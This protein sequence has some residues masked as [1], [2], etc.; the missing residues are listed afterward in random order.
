MPNQFKI[1]VDGINSLQATQGKL[2]EVIWT[3]RKA[4]V[5]DCLI[6]QSL[7]K[8]SPQLESLKLSDLDMT[9]SGLAQIHQALVPTHPRTNQ[10]HPS[11]SSSP[12]LVSLDLNRNKLGSSDLIG[13]I[14]RWTRLEKVLLVRNNLR[15]PGL[16]GICDALTWNPVHLKHLDL[17]SNSICPLGA[18]RMAQILGKDR[19]GLMKLGLGY[20]LL[21]DVGCQFICR[22]LTR[23]DLVNCNRGH[24]SQSRLQ[25][26]NLSHNQIT[27]AA[28]PVICSMI[29]NNVGLQTL[30][31]SHNFF[32]EAGAA[33][34]VKALGENISLTKVTIRSR[35]LHQSSLLV[36]QIESI[37]KRNQDHL[38][39]LSCS[40][41]SSLKLL[42]L[43]SFLPTE[44]LS[45]ILGYHTDHL[46]SR[47][48]NLVY[49]LLL[50]KD[51][52]LGLVKSDNVFS[53][54][55][56]LTLCSN[57]KNN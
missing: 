3:D 43:R 33:E 13:D 15:S 49:S 40:I 16:I 44:L 5:N 21:G 41:P 22:A 14:V 31:L 52:H 39:S 30:N 28:V 46:S 55:S 45:M 26:L 18:K 4:T 57:S 25:E 53:H 6:V 7:I 8:Q 38:Q 37:C 54:L 10:F 19:I 29:R 9:D 1:L 50:D 12:F 32:T 47:D 2:L 27:D 56:F 20:N 24:Q 51:R 34:I 11:M 36:Q 42:L 17:T 48:Q 23:G 35:I